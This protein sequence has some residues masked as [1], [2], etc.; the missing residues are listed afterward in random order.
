MSAMAKPPKLD[1]VKRVRSK[2][3][4]Y[5]YFKANRTGKPVLIRLPPMS[6]P[7][8]W[9]RYAALKAARERKAVQAYTVA[10]MIADY[11]RSEEFE[12]K[13]PATRRL[14]G[15]QFRR[16][17]NIFGKFHVNEVEPSHVRHVLSAER[18]PAGTRNAFIGALG[19]LYKWGRHHDKTAMHPTKDVARGKG[20]EYEPWPDDVLEAAL[21]SEN[22]LVRLSVH[23]L[24]FTGQ[25]IGDICKLRWSDYRNGGFTMQQQKTGKLMQIPAHAELSAELDRTPRQGITII[26]GENGKPLRPDALRAELKAFTRSQGHETVPHG[27]RKNA[28]NA[29]LEQQCTIA[30]VAAITGQTYAIVE[31]YAARVNTRKL[32]RAAMLKFETGRK[33]NEKTFGKRKA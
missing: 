19:S 27:L 29:M 3:R 1:H 8:F 13:A 22:D 11:E 32:G 12:N 15:I 16:I 17:E 33:G 14:Y 24:Y 25:R 26:A 28:V 6:S 23:L 20:G 7:D 30:E 4:D 18:W 31:H 9:P 10:T 2:G 5:L 21:A